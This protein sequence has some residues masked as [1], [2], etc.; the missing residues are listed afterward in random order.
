MELDVFLC[1]LPPYSIIIG[2]SSTAVEIML[3]A[4]MLDRSHGSKEDMKSLTFF[5]TDNN[6]LHNAIQKG[7]H[8][9]PI[10][11][12]TRHLAGAITPTVGVS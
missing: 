2:D 9:S 6:H 4:E 7:H 8:V 12:L 10:L 1:L 5:R 11:L 3:W